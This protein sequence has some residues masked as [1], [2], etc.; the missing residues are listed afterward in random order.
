MYLNLCRTLPLDWTIAKFWQAHALDNQTSGL[1]FFLVKFGW[2]QHEHRSNKWSTSW[3]IVGK[4]KHVDSERQ[5]NHQMNA[6][7]GIRTKFG[8]DWNMTLNIEQVLASSVFTFHHDNMVYWPTQWTE[9]HN[10]LQNYMDGSIEARADR[11]LGQAKANLHSMVQ[12]R[13]TETVRI[14]RHCKPREEN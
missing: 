4:L 3:E 10:V 5:I 2:S 14:L 13:L 12:V 8:V 6:Q 1:F 7:I 9:V 11:S